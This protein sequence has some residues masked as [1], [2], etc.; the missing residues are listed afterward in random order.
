[1]AVKTRTDLKTYFQTGD[2]PTEAQFVDLLDSVWLKG[3]YIPISQVTYGELALTPSPANVVTFD[4]SAG[5]NAAVTLTAN[6]TL[7]ITNALP[8][9]Q[10][11]LRVKQD[12]TGGRTLGLP[13]GAKVGYGGAGAITLSAAANAEDIVTFYCVSSTSFR[14]L[15]NQNFS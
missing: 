13:A 8:G 4:A 15:V 10:L 9:Q 2:K 6:S 1:M 12:G 11:L 7:A 14:V 3:D 5:G